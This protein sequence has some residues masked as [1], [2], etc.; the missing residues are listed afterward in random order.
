MAIIFFSHGSADYPIVES[1]KN[2]LEQM[3]SEVYLF[4]HDRQPNQDVASKVQKHIDRAD[5]VTVL[6]TKQSQHS[7]YVHQE[8]GYAERA[9]KPIL[10]LVEN[11]T[12]PNT[13]AMLAGREHIPFD[14][15]N[16]YK[17][18]SAMQTFIHNHER[19][20]LYAGAAATAAIIVLA[21]ILAYYMS[22]S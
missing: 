2:E 18:L 12:D 9:G 7:P 15:S 11:G 1:F 22:K 10:P 16:P 4:E 19:E 13:L 14:P 3:K 8:I 20:A 6:L 17:S 5:I 21:L